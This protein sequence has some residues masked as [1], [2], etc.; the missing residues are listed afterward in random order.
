MQNPLLQLY[1]LRFVSSVSKLSKLFYSC[2][3]KKKNKSA[4]KFMGIT[5][6][7]RVVCHQFHVGGV[8]LSTIVP[9]S[10]PG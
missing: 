3:L 2:F 9:D 6:V 7:W 1:F 10:P 4:L 5:T 8:I